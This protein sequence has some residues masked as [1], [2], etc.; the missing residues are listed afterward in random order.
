M[1]IFL[2]QAFKSMLKV[3]VIMKTSFFFWDYQNEILRAIR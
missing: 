3:T 1:L 2:N